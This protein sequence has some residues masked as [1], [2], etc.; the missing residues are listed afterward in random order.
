[1]DREEHD[2]KHADRDEG[3]RVG[4]V[5]RRVGPID[6]LVHQPRRLEG[7]RGLEDHANLLAVLVKRDDVVRGGLVVASMALVLLAVTKQIA[8]QLT[9]VL[10]ARLLQG[11]RLALAKETVELPADPGRVR[12]YRQSDGSLLGSAQLQA[13]GILAPERLIRTEHT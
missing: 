4:V 6:E 1:M 7:S 5:E 13:G 2:R 11:Q 8:V 9:D 12:V 10:A 3:M